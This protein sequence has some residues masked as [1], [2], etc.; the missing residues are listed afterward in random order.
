MVTWWL[1]EPMTFEDVAVFFSNEEW[2]ILR[3]SEKELYRNVMRENYENM[4]SLGFQIPL[5]YA[6]LFIKNEEALMCES[7]IKREEVEMK[8]SSRHSFAKSLKIVCLPFDLLPSATF[9][10]VGLCV[11]SK[12]VDCINKSTRANKTPN[13]LLEKPFQCHECGKNFLNLRNLRVHFR[14]H[15]GEKPFKCEDCERQFSQQGHLREHR[16]LHT[17]EK[18]YK[19]D[20]CEKRFCQRSNLRFHQLSHTG[21]RPY[22]CD[23][24]QKTFTQVCHFKEHQWTHT[25]ERPYKCRLCEMT[26]GRRGALRTHERAHIGGKPYKCPKCEKGFDRRSLLEVHLQLHRKERTF[27]CVECDT[28]FSCLQNLQNHKIHCR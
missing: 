3:D 25:G 8:T 24:C 1:E 11:V 5:H 22:K 7:A 21:E 15:S 10:N 27:V 23:K 19:C 6:S 18:P 12:A 14:M 20:E 17:G 9:S 2:G 26:F 28:N 16:R 4:I 13:H